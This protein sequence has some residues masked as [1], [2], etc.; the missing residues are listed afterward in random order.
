MGSWLESVTA[1]MLSRHPYDEVAYD[2]YELANPPVTY[3]YGRVGTLA[4]E[5][6]LAEFAEVA[7]SVL[8][9]RWP[10]VHGDPG[11]PVRKVAVCGGSG[12][13]LFREAAGAG[14]DVYVTGDTKHHD[15]LDAA[16]LGVAVIDAGHF[17]TEKPGHGGA[18]REAKEDLPGGWC[19]DRLHRVAMG[20]G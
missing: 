5:V 18:H 17:E 10:K 6:G 4:N 16:D 14:A 1:A 19:G 7:K 20:V 8:E 15:I 12:S 2:V 13:S 11:K 9:V 3:G